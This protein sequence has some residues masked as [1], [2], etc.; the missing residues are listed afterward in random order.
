M[1]N[2]LK[3]LNYL[4]KD[5]NSLKK[6]SESLLLLQTE[7]P[8]SSYNFSLKRLSSILFVSLLLLFY[9][10]VVNAQVIPTDGPGGPILVISTTSNPFSRYYAEILRAE[11]F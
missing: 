10:T 6:L 7:K 11:G 3:S 1:E 8:I 4:L 5:K 9:S 2:I